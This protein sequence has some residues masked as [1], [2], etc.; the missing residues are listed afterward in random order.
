MTTSPARIDEFRQK[1]SWCEI[2]Q[3]AGLYH[4]LLQTCV[5]EDLGNTSDHPVWRNDLTTSVCGLRGNGSAQLVA[6]EPFV[7]CGVKLA[8]LLLPI[9]S[10]DEVEFLPLLS[11]GHFCQAGDLI[12]TLKGAVPQILAIERTLLNFIQR[13]AELQPKLLLSSLFLN[14]KELNYWIRVKRLPD[15][16][17]LRNLPPLVGVHLIIEWA[18]LTAS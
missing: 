13:Y 15:F 18:F 1:I 10:C 7:L 17:Y 8:D 5:E 14:K 2:K 3:S 16:E 9:F 11:D 6:R 12:G 4:S